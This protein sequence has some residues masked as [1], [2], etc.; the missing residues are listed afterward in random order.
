VAVQGTEHERVFDLFGSQV[1]LLIGPPAQPGLEP[2]A[3]AALSLEAFLRGFH[4]RLT[5]FDPRSELCKLNADRSERLRVSPLLAL[6]LRAGLTAA[7]ASGGLVDPTLTD[8]IERAGYTRS[9]AGVA[10]APL[11]DALAVAPPRRPA[12]PRRSPGWSRFSVD[13]RA[14]IVERPAGLRFDTGGSGKGLAADLCAARLVGYA[15]FAVDA[16]GDLRIGGS[17]PA[18]RLVEIEHPMRGGPAHTFRLSEGAVATSGIS[19]RI[20][21]DGDRFAHHLLD[22]STGE[23]A[24]TGVVQATALGD[25]ALEAETLAKAALLSGPERGAELLAPLGGMLVLDDGEVVHAGPQVAD[26]DRARALTAA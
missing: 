23:P 7:E 16:G 13:P 10:G 3:L 6:A 12:R 25:T 15:T 11:A 4:A 2:P 17:E 24:W 9:R 8:E 26:R 21:R 22:P 5:R 14:G 20:W 1:R 18:V 19:T